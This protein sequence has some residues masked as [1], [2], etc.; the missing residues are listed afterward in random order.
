MS[1]RALVL[2]A[3]GLA[4]LVGCTHVAHLKHGERPKA[5]ERIVQLQTLEGRILEFDQAGGR[6]AAAD[7]TVTGRARV[8]PYD[9]TDLCDGQRKPDLRGV[10]WTPVSVPA[11]SVT[12]F[13]VRRIDRAGDVATLV[14]ATVV[15]IGAVTD[16]AQMSKETCAFFFA[17][18]GG[19]YVSDAYPL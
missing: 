19:L 11:D 16:M 1:R 10:A 14:A 12:Q 5:E 4:V 13:W 7:S 17:Y 15:L 2:L 9:L 8:V 3:T 6:Y 18:D